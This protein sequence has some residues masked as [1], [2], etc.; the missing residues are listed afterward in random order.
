MK[1]EGLT[2]RTPSLERRCTTPGHSHRLATKRLGK[3][4][5]C[6][7]CADRYLIEFAKMVKVAR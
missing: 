2:I 6:A 3:R 1:P 7:Q 4:W 5:R